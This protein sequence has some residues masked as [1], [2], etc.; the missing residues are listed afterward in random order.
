MNAYYETTYRSDYKGQ[1]APPLRKIVRGFLGASERRT[2]LRA[3]LVPHEGRRM[4]DVGCGAGELVYLMR[5]DGV[6][7]SG[8]DPGV[9]FAEFARTGPSRA[10]S[11]R[12]G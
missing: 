2:M 12:G 4:L 11:N 8:L 1:S 5:R 3:F 9:E 7:A 6:D 10:G